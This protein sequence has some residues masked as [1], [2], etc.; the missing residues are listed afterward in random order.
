MSA[1]VHRFGRLARAAL[2]ASAAALAGCGGGLWI[3]YSDVDDD[4]PEVSLVADT[5]SAEPGQLL[6]LSAAASD[7]GFVERVR[8]YRIDDDGRALFLGDDLGSPYQLETPLPYT[9]AVQVR[10][11]ARAFDDFGQWNDSEV[12]SVTVLR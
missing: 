12:V 6:R 2:L 9:T 11:F 10:Y 4:L 3:G 8:F 1:R 7:D 5:G